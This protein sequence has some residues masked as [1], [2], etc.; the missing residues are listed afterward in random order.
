M[1]MESRRKIKL[2]DDEAKYDTVRPKCGWWPG[3]W[4]KAKLRGR[5]GIE[6][7]EEELK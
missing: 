5:G 1:I 7:K 6:G 4:I 3:R 2:K